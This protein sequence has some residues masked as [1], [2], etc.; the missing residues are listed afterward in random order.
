MAEPLSIQKG[1]QLLV[2]GKDQL[3]FFEAFVKHLS[4]SNIQI[5]NFGGIN[6]LNGF[7][8]AFVKSPG[9]D[10]VRSIGVV[11]DAENSGQ[12]ALQSVL[13]SLRNAGLHIQTEERSESNHIP[14]VR[15]LILPT[16]EDSSGMLE[17]LLCQ[18]F[19]RGEV[20]HCIDEF[21]E[22]VETLPGIFIAN[23]D[24]ARAFV[25]LATKRNPH[26]SVGVAALQGVWDLDH[27][28]FESVRD[29]LKAL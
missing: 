10:T 22:C 21:F 14:M 29:F 6:E 26:H 28:A 12:A 15:V 24:K 18:T 9:W 17:T 2:E 20:N 3:N 19:E 11:R 4:L 27:E 5:H 13:G 25:Y 23:L 8:S 1:K 16:E 7:L